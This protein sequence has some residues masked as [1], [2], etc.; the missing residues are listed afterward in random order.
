LS[1]RKLLVIGK[2]KR[3]NARIDQ[4]TPGWD[5]PE[6]K[7]KQ[8]VNDKKRKS[9]RTAFSIQTVGKPLRCDGKKLADRPIPR[10][11]KEKNISGD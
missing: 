8:R 7:K 3:G 6:G 4:K 11:G 2:V 10:S 9:G 1:L 5:R